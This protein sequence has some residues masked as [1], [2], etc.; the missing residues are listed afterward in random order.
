MLQHLLW[1]RWPLVVKSFVPYESVRIVGER[2]G[3]YTRD[4]KKIVGSIPTWP[5]IKKRDSPQ[6]VSLLSFPVVLESG[7]SFIVICKVR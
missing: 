5:T 1:V 4:M 7:H 6:R 2:S 3:L